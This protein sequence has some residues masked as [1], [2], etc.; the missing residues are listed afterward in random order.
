MKNNENDI[1]DL[2]KESLGNYEAEVRPSVWKNIRIGLKWGGVAL[3]FNTLINKIGVTTVIAIVSSAV[4]IGTVAIMKRSNNT[5][6]TKQTARTGTSVLAPEKIEK[7]TSDANS[8]SAQ[9]SAPTVSTASSENGNDKNGTESVKKATTTIVA[10]AEVP[11]T[12]INK[13]SKTKTTIDSLIK[14][15]S[16]S[17]IS[18][19]EFSP[20]GDGVVDVFVFQTK[21]IAS[22]SA[23]IFDKTGT[24]VFTSEITGAKWDGKDLQGK[25]AKEGIYFYTINAE[26]ANGK[27]Y[28]PTGAIKLTR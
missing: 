8:S 18:P 23:K 7:Q 28:H 13:E 1:E 22:M 15:I 10:H 2:F 11:K 3:F 16:S 20:N 25:D 19:T 17:S 6:E 12:I 5:A 26:G 24:I 27:K 21:N 9:P 14:A 4:I